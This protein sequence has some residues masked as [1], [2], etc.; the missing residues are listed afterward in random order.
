M[1][2]GISRRWLINTIGVIA[3][4]LIVFITVLSITIQSSTYNGIQQTLVGRSDELLNALSSGTGGYKTPSEFTSISRVYIE[5]FPDKNSM[6]IMSLNRNGRV[7]IT[8]TGFAPNESSA[9]PD[10][11]SAISNP[12]NS[13]N[14]VGKMDTGEKVMAVTRVVRDP[15]GSPV[16]SI[17]YVVSLEKA[18]R[19]ITFI[20]L[21]LVLVGVFVMLVITI[22]GLYFLRS[23]LDPI[24]QISLTAKQI[25]QGDFDVRV[26]RSKDDEIGLLCDSINDMAVG[27]GASERMKNDFISSVS[28]EL[29]TPLTS[30]KGWAET[31][32]SGEID[33]TTN[34]KGMN[35]IIRESERLT[36]IVEELLDF[37]R[38]QSGGMKLNLTKIDIF[39]ELDE[40]V[41][42]FTDRAN[43][44]EKN[45]N[46]TEN[47]TITP[48]FGD[49]N[50]LRQVFVNIIDN[51]L[52]YTEKGG[53]ISVASGE[54]N[55]YINVIITDTGCGIPNEHLPNIKNKFY[56]ANQLVRG[57][58]IGLAVANEI[59]LLHSG[60]LDIESEVGV[61]T[62]VTITL[63]TMKTLLENPTLSTTSEMKKIAERTKEINE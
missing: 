28:H 51:A 54:S 7:V 47:T 24:H 8:S 48:L 20:I 44:E 53:N 16:G 63:P 25:S 22:S 19:Q 59:V 29:R 9:M 12:D 30:I 38:I 50:R 11:I 60:K 55:G 31:L 21:T 57:S 23:I 35:V 40:A 1:R 15:F 37:S 62:S 49:I 13:G 26:E 42:M 3:V 45:L 33:T 6:E 17:R 52:K 10:Y 41:Y 34:E 56:K 39:S 27:L 2:K 14:W 46:Y 61:G 4:I 36:G 18:D 43:T 58:G 32:H 5:N